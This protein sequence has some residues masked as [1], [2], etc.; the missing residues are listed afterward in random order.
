MDRKQDKSKNEVHYR[1]GNNRQSTLS[2]SFAA[3]LTVFRCNL[4]LLTAFDHHSLRMY[5]IGSDFTIDIKP[6]FQL[7]LK[8]SIL[9]LAT[10]HISAGVER[11]EIDIFDFI[12]LSQP[13]RDHLPL[14]NFNNFGIFPGHSCIT[15]ERQQTECE[16]SFTAF[17]RKQ[18]RAETDSEFPYKNT[19]AFGEII[20]SPFMDGHQNKKHKHR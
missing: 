3:K 20:M 4:R 8:I 14:A 6:D 19:G 12:V 11:I 13:H 18:F 9:R 15:T 7:I 1:S 17:I 2:D 5:I 10:D 16:L